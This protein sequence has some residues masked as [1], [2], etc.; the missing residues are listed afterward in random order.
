[1]TGYQMS[2]GMNK[3]TNKYQLIELE[4]DFT[5]KKVHICMVVP[6]RQRFKYISFVIWAGILIDISE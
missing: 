3:L 5:E 2:E 4:C 1:M 6:N